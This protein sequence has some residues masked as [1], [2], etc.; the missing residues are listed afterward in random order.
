MDA[1]ER[2]QCWLNLARAKLESG[3]DYPLIDTQYL[4]FE[5]LWECCTNSNFRDSVYGLLES[6]IA[7]N[8]GDNCVRFLALSLYYR[9]AEIA[10]HE[11]ERDERFR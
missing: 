1:E 5:D 11:K 3:K 6:A 8:P 2:I 10:R 4:P 7:R 9:L